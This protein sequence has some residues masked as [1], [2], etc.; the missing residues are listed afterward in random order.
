MRALPILASLFERFCGE[1]AAVDASAG[2]D[3]ASAMVAISR[4]LRMKNMHTGGGEGVSCRCL[5]LLSGRGHMINNAK[6][7]PL[8]RD[9]W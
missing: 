8:A 2:C 1:G 5:V 9:R 6:S 4:G 3:V 7:I